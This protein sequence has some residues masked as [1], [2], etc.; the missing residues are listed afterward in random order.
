MRSVV[1]VCGMLICIIGAYS[2]GRIW[3]DRSKVGS[4]VQRPLYY[5]DPMHPSYR[6]DKPGLAPDC[7]MKLE[8]VF[9]EGPNSRPAAGVSPTLP[10]GTIHVDDVT[11]KLIGLQLMSVSRQPRASSLTVIGRIKPED[12]RTY[13]L[14]SGVDGFVRQT[15]DDSTGSLV[16]KNQKLA[17]YYSPEFLA[18]MS[19]F[20]A[21][22]ERIPGS[23]TG[24]GI[25][26]IQTYSDRLRNMGMSELQIKQVASTRQYPE[27]VE[28]LSPVNGVILTRA[29][30]P[31]QHFER[32][33]ELYQ[34]ADLTKVWVIAEVDE[35]DEPYLRPGATANIRLRT[36]SLS[37]TARVMNS[38]PES[39]LA[40]GTV[41]VRLEADNPRFTL[42]PNMLVD[43]QLAR[44]R[45]P[46]ISVPVDAVVD[47]GVN[48]RVYVA[49]ERGLFQPRAV[50]IGWRDSD[51][52][53]IK[54]GLRTGERIVANSAFL[55]DSESRLKSMS[56]FPN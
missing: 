34:V 3:P 46:S 51:N 4:L 49:T 47:P 22:N 42:R 23:V 17:T 20:L 52:I 8:P 35:Q 13:K 55:I 56:T 50:E 12:D 37:M 38:L 40:G 11:Q 41:K 14:N 31:G 30:S 9:D 21:A 6:S 45:P 5:V 33:T 32:N 53:E 43:V 16:Q 18:A 39:D 24:E 19:G 27:S 44:R 7:G 54:K 25:R 48:P 10:A 15:F 36:A 1:G 26:S 28:V 2:V 29:V